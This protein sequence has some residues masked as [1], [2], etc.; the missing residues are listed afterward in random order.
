MYI[1]AKVS[2]PELDRNRHTVSNLALQL[3][4][5]QHLDQS[6]SPEHQVPL[7]KSTGMSTPTHRGI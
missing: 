7:L 5:P 3:R 6:L 2:M 1:Q 4:L